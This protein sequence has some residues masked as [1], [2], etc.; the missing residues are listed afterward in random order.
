[1]TA[2]HE[3]TGQEDRPLLDRAAVERLNCLLSEAADMS[4]GIGRLLDVEHPMDCL[5]ALKELRKALDQRL[6]RAM[7]VLAGDEE[8]G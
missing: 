4:V 5:D 1:M 2:T 7:N 8:E 3:E 6:A